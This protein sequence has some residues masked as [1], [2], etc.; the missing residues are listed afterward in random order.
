MST[1]NG[2]LIHAD[3]DSYEGEWKNDKANGQGKYLHLDGA[4]YE[5]GWLED[6]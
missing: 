6:K 4:K 3:G 1:G 2:R 5:G